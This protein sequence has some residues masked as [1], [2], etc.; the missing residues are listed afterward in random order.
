MAGSNLS[1]LVNAGGDPLGLAVAGANVRDTKL[2]DLTPKCI[3]LERPDNNAEAF[4][5][6]CLNKGYVNITGHRMVASQGC[7]DHIRR[8][9]GGQT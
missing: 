5:H 3:L 7:R 9:G 4:Q 1:V 2:L 6:L 8:I